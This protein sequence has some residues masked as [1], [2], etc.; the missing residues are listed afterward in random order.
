MAA[1]TVKR[2]RAAYQ[3]EYRRKNPDKVRGY[4]IACYPKKRIAA[5]LWRAKNSAKL[6]AKDRQRRLSL[7]YGLTEESYSAMVAAQGGLC[8]ICNAPPLNRKSTRGRV[9]ARLDVDHCHESGKVRALLCYNC[10]AILGNARDS[11]EVLRSAVKY[12]EKYRYAE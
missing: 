2:Q 4:Q 8:A 5:K 1:E 10:N 7:K 3:R 9:Y 6:H 12:L 11:L